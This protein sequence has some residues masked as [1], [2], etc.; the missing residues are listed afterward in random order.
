VEF[1]SD[2]FMEDGYTCVF[3]QDHTMYR[4]SFK[5]GRVT[6]QT[7]ANP[8]GDDVRNTKTIINLSVSKKNLRQESNVG[9]TSLDLYDLLI[10][11]DTFKYKVIEAYEEVSGNGTSSEN[12]SVL[13]RKQIRWWNENLQQMIL[14][15]PPENKLAVKFALKCAKKVL[16]KVRPRFSFI[17]KL[18][19]CP[20]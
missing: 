2:F 8:N 12:K 4:V 20:I 6:L 16:S 18:I 3:Y 10:Q 15:S 13:S 14:V 7:I 5:H 17:H 11:F 19:K 9:Y 1:S